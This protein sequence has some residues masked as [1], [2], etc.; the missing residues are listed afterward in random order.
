MDNFKNVE[1]ISERF[2]KRISVQKSV[3]IG[4]AVYDANIDLISEYQRFHLTMN[5]FAKQ[6]Q[7]QT[8]V[9]KKITW[10]IYEKKSFDKLIENVTRFMHDL[11][12]LF[13][14]AQKNQKNVL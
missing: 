12:D 9:R 1:R 2:K 8:N 7:K 13:P 5:K 10:A 14:A 6:R 11:V 4:L 3:F